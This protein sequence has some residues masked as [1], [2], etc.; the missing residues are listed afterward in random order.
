MTEVIYNPGRQRSQFTII[1]RNPEERLD[2]FGE[3][4]QEAGD[5][6]SFPKNEG[7]S[8]A[9]IFGSDEEFQNE[10]DKLMGMNCQLFPGDKAR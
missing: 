5:N 8:K 7:M 9:E 4:E 3:I 2:M 6:E 1:F 10:I